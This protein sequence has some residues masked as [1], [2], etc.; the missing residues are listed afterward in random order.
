MYMCLLYSLLVY[1]KISRMRYITGQSE[2]MAT[3]RAMVKQSHNPNIQLMMW[4]FHEKT[5]S[6]PHL[7]LSYLHRKKSNVALHETINETTNVQQCTCPKVQYWLVNKS[8][9]T[10]AI[11]VI[12]FALKNCG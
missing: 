10:K 7:P 9:Q 11:G 4:L 6:F 5:I 12:N 1:P 2:Y 8:N 3:P